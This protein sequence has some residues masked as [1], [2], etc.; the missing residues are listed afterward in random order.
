MSS[1]LPC[2]GGLDG[3]DSCHLPNPCRSKR[4]VDAHMRTVEWILERGRCPELVAR[5]EG[6]VVPCES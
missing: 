3:Q 4:E 1:P 6:W 2:Q 5:D